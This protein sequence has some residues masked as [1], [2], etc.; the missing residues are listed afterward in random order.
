MTRR[1]IHAAQE[2]HQAQAQL[3]QGHH[4]EALDTYLDILSRHPAGVRCRAPIAQAAAFLAFDLGCFFL[5]QRLAGAAVDE[6]SQWPVPRRQRGAAFLTMGRTEVRLGDEEAAD[7]LSG[8]YLPG[9]WPWT[10]RSQ[11]RAAQAELTARTGAGHTEGE[12]SPAAAKARYR[13]LSKRTGRRLRAVRQV[14]YAQALLAA[15]EPEWAVAHFAAAVGTLSR[16]RPVTRWVEQGIP[17]GDQHGQQA[18]LA[19]AHAVTGQVHSPTAPDQPHARAC[20]SAIDL[21]LRLGHHPAA[22]NAAVELSDKAHQ[23]EQPDLAA[24]ALERVAG[25]RSD[26]ICWYVDDTL[27]SRWASSASNVLRLVRTTQPDATA[28]DVGWLTPDSGQRVLTAIETIYAALRKVDQENFARAEAA[29]YENLAIYVDR[30]GL[31]DLAL[32]ASDR[33]VAVLRDRIDKQGDDAREGLAWALH[34]HAICLTDAGVTVGV[35]ASW[36]EA[37]ELHFRLGHVG[38]LKLAH[39]RLTD[40][41]VATGEWRDAA[42]AAVLGASRI[43]SLTGE[44]PLPAIDTALGEIEV[45]AFEQNLAA[46]VEELADERLE[47]SALMAAWDPET[48][49]APYVQLLISRAVRPDLPEDERWEG[50]Q[51]AVAVSRSLGPAQHREEGDLLAKALTASAEFALEHGLANEAL[52]CTDETIDRHRAGIEAGQS[53]QSK[54][55]AAIMRRD[56]C[57]SALDRQDA[58]TACLTD[59]YTVIRE[60]R[61]LRLDL[62]TDVGEIAARLWDIDAADLAVQVLSD[63][64][65]WEQVSD[66]GRATHYERRAYYLACMRRPEE[67]LHDLEAAAQFA[68]DADWLA[69]RRGR[70]LSLL[71]MRYEAREAF[72]ALANSHPDDPYPR[73]MLG[74]I[75]LDSGDAGGAVGDLLEAVRLRPDGVANRTALAYAY[76]ALGDADA[77]LRHGHLAADLADADAEAHYV[78]GL[79]LRIYGDDADGD[80]ELARAVT[81]VNPGKPPLAG[82]RFAYRAVFEAARG[83]GR[84]AV[85]QLYR[86]T[87]IGLTPEM[88]AYLRT[89]LQIIDTH[90]PYA[91]EAC[92]AMKS[93]IGLIS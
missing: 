61:E 72:A 83:R 34:R 58:R 53:R 76:L 13:K 85:D 89:Q 54:L 50:L 25:R 88:V 16:C 21:F 59:A 24:A 5:A 67:A 19:W 20:L 15:E 31:P 42:S 35:A 26:S 14:G 43:A 93:A 44:S 8:T 28:G 51:T 12:P 37:A 65:T 3:S 6:T 92:A 46:T 11:V 66:F 70:I 4:D 49:A 17:P 86:G 74:L 52:A 27:V 48:R 33:E 90:L 56:R 2:I 55:V 45:Q 62:H 75:K 40:F 78:H 69:R 64:L 9:G 82:D 81:L 77:A 39:K 68:A 84:D 23:A 22:F 63:A 38:A 73:R 29:A 47:L 30:I 41:L 10:L 36:S 91:A 60:W 7:T 80:A 57:L 79:A 1:C 71:G 87:R 32:A 18:C